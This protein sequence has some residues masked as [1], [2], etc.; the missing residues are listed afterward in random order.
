VAVLQKKNE[1]LLLDLPMD[2]LQNI[3]SQLNFAQQ[4]MLRSVC[5]DLRHHHTAY[6][7]HFH[8]AYVQ[9]H[10]EKW[11]ESVKERKLRVMLQT[12]KLAVCYYMH[13]DFEWHFGNSLFLFHQELS[14]GLY[15]PNE[16]EDPEPG[17]LSRFIRHFQLSLE[18]PLSTE[19]P[20][21]RLQEKRLLFTLSIFH[22]LRQFPTFRISGLGMCL[23]HWQLQ[24]EVGHVFVGIIKD[25]EV[26]P[27]TVDREKRIDFMSVMAELLFYEKLQKEFNCFKEVGTI[28]YSYGRHLQTLAKRKSSLLLKFMVLAPQSVLRMLQDAITGK[29]DPR[30]PISVP[31]GSAIS[32][33]LEVISKRPSRFID[34]AP[35]HIS[36][37]QLSELI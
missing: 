2:L 16:D 34:L 3:I 19:C 26:N 11:E 10:R 35:L 15:R 28:V 30:K 7:M 17:C 27:H 36:F 14:R 18:R 1:M 24:V 8:E 5:T 6:I 33:R 31:P 23:M 20:R 22:L 13:K 9:A 29:Y 21:K 12:Q 32:I 4:K 37:L 25:W